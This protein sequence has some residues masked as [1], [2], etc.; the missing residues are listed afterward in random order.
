V[1]VLLADVSFARLC[2]AKEKLILTSAF[3]DSMIS[4][5]AIVVV[6]LGVVSVAVLAGSYAE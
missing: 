2:I 1:R 4:A 5:E 6:L 3:S